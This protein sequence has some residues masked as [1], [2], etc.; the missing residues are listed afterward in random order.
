MEPCQHQ[1]LKRH[2]QLRHQPGSS[3]LWVGNPEDWAL[4]R[5]PPRPPLV[6]PEPGCEVELISYENLRNKYNPR[7]FKFK[8]VEKSC[9]HWVADGQGGGPESAHHEWMKLRL[10]RIAKRLGY[11]T[12][13]EH[14]PTHADVFVHEASYCL[15]VQ[16]RPTQFRQRTAARTA[17][18]MKVC[19]L[20]R[21]GLDTEKARQAL[22]GLPA[23]RFRVMDREDRGRLLT[24][25]DNP[26][27]RELAHRARLEVFGTIAC[28]LPADKRGDRATPAG[29]WFRTHTM[30]GFAFLDEILAGRRRWY[31]PGMLGQKRGL[32]VLKTDVADYYA[33]RQQVREGGT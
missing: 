24:P 32:W 19:W 23:V 18:G 16:L 25:W 31:R 30:D 7:I 20:I 4:V 1:Q 10:A 3:P 2:A 8:S 14:A 27:D 29:T 15:E 6:C 28:A 22:F 26:D 12:T 13:P 11:T 21:E 17:K 5:H 33:F 9:D